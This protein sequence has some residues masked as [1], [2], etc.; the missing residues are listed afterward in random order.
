[1]QKSQSARGP[2]Q[3]KSGLG[4]NNSPQPGQF[5][6]NK[7]LLK[8]KATLRGMFIEQNFESRGPGPP[9]R[10]CTPITGCFHDKTIT[11]KENFRVDCYSLLKYCRRQ[12][13]GTLLPPTWTKSLTKFNPKMH[14]FQRVL[15]LN[16]KQKKD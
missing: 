11:S 4:N 12:C 10:I 15:D 13:T 7:I 8:K 14:D 6:C 16:C 5:L 1:M 2:T 3:C 9:G